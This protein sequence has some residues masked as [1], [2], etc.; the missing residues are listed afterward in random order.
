MCDRQS[1]AACEKQ[2]RVDQWQAKR[3]HRFIVTANIA[4]AIGR[5]GALVALPQQNIRKEVVAIAA[6]PGNS[7]IAGIEKRA[8]KCCEEHHFRKN[9]PEHPHAKRHANLG[10]ITTALAFTDHFAKPANEHER[11]DCKTDEHDP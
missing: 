2:R 11:D 3:R 8:K 9:K 7:H 6:E 10:V 1:H 4:G 5:P